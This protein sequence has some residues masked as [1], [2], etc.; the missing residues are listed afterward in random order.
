ME[1]YKPTNHQHGFK[2]AGHNHPWRENYQACREYDTRG[3]AQG[4]QHYSTGVR[5][6]E[7]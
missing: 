7:G 1:I 4:R 2:D 3:V 6:K 5:G